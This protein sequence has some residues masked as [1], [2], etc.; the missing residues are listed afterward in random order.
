MRKDVPERTSFFARSYRNQSRQLSADPYARD[1]ANDAEQRVE[2]REGMF[3]CGDFPFS[4]FEYGA[5][6]G[7]GDIFREC[8]VARLSGQVHAAKTN[9]CV[10]RRRTEGSGHKET[11]VQSDRREG[12]TIF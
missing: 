8:L 11:C 12:K 3:D 6:L 2:G 5:S 10:L 1:A 7:S 4:P 9:A